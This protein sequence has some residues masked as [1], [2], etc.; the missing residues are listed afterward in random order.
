MPSW[1]SLYKT[2]AVCFWCLVSALLTH[3]HQGQQLLA[4]DG[5]MGCTSFLSTVYWKKFE[6]DGALNGILYLL[7][8]VAEP[9]TG[10][11]IG[12]K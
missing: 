11:S 8:A 4:G 9:G 2:S 1:V 10:Q 3:K 7:L 6:V 5:E 12:F